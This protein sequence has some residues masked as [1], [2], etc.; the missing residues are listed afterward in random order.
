MMRYGMHKITPFWYFVVMMTAR[1]GLM[2]R[3]VGKRLNSTLAA[4]Y[5]EY[6]KARDVLK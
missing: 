2:L 5:T 6:G 3:S 4:Q 1:Y